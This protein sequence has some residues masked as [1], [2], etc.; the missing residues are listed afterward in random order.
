LA[1]ALAAPA[2]AQTIQGIL[3]E[4][5]HPTTRDHVELTVVGTQH[6]N[7]P[8]A[9]TH[10]GADP[11]SGGSL[12]VIRGNQPECPF[13]L[14]PEESFRKTFVVPKLLPAGDY[15]VIAEIES[16]IPPFVGTISSWDEAFEV[17]EPDPVLML[18]QDNGFHVFVE[19][20]NPHDGSHGAG[21]AL[22]SARDSGAFWF[23]SSTNL[24]TT[25]KILDGRPVN[26]HWW[27]FIANMTDLEVKVT[28]A[29]I[30]VGFCL[31]DVPQSC[32]TK[33]YT[34]SAGTSRNFIDVEAFPE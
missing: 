11:A 15:L 4:P 32:P 10:F 30:G 24:E 16:F 9:W 33:T 14:S 21:Y 8:V 25:V 2:G 1:L 31:E 29:K 3:V 12:W 17:T 34:Q 13:P 19:W 20:S 23:F 28:V 18:G 26:G 5:A 27:V 7:C 6:G 22:R